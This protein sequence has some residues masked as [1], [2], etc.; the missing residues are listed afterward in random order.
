MELKTIRE[1]N[2][3]CQ[4]GGHHGEP[5]YA[6]V[7]GYSHNIRIVAARDHCGILQVKMIGSGAWLQPQRVFTD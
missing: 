1:I 4:T 7:A 3:A 5:V 2:E 6:E